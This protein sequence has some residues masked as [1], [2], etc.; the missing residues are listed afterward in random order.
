MENEELFR[1]EKELFNVDKELE[2]QKGRRSLILITIYA[3]VVGFII[4]HFFKKIT[5]ETIFTIIIISLIS[6][7]VLWIVPLSVFHLVTDLFTNINSLDV[8]K[9]HLTERINDIRLKH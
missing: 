3:V 9:K 5:L 7:V 4:S 2:K 6:G 1:L 8:R